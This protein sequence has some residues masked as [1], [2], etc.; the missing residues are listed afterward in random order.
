MAF[1]SG[2]KNDIKLG[3]YIGIGLA[4]LGLLLG[5][6]RMAASKVSRG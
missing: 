1:D 5:V 2:A 4:L 6:I 3:F